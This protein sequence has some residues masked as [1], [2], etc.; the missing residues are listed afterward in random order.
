MTML[1]HFDENVPL[2]LLA[3]CRHHA[4]ANHVLQ[5]GIKCWAPP[6]IPRTSILHFSGSNQNILKCDTIFT[7][8]MELKAQRKQRGIEREENI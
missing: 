4:Q 8:R 7:A 1:L 3:S 2:P 6:S 5:P